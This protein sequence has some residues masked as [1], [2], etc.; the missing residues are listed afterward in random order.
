[1]DIKKNRLYPYPVLAYYNSD[2]CE[3]QFSVKVGID[4][5]ED[6]VVIHFNV[7][8]VNDELKELIKNQMAVLVYHV[9]NPITCYRK[10]FE[11]GEED[12]SIRIPAE[13]LN[14][15]ISI[16]S[17]IISRNAIPN[18]SNNKFNSDYEGA[19]FSIT[20]GNI[21]GIAPQVKIHI[22]KARDELEKM[23]S[24]FSIIRTDEA[25][26][27]VMKIEIA[28]EKIKLFLEKSVF[29]TYQLLSMNANYLPVL[30]SAL[31]FPALVSTLDSI[32]HEG[33]EEYEDYR[34]FRSIKKNMNKQGLELNSE[35][36]R[37][38]TSFVL[39]QEL[40]NYPI[41]KGFEKLLAEGNDE[42]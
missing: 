14:G 2:F 16:C 24:I 7:T 4:Q 3:S 36:I 33:V 38:K 29:E 1:M 39:A 35:Q 31:I 21:L 40:L 10:I 11:T 15:R 37:M 8:L 22:D 32:Q 30:H 17:F 12:F 34:W 26:S 18:Y 13:K 23:P 28:S 6:N 41:V 19:S 42:D 20:R 25:E 27:Q 9:E 5:Q